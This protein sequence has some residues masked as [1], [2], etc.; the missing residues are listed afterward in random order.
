MT[1]DKTLLS[2]LCEVNGQKGGTIWQFLERTKDNTRQDWQYFARAY[3]DCIACGITFP[4]RASF[5]KLA[6]QNHI[7]INWE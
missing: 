3:Y 5:N 1:I 2:N 6:A 7:M 4:S